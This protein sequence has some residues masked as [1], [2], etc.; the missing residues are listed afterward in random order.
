MEKGIVDGTPSRADHRLIAYIIDVFF[1]KKSV[2]QEPAEFDRVSRVFG[3]AGGSWERLYKGSATDFNLLR[4][5][6]KIAIAQ[7][8]ISESPGFR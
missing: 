6:V 7:G 4:R 2:R 8:Q 1:K 5:I 3:L